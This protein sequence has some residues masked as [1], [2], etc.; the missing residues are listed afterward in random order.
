MFFDL[1]LLRYLY[2]YVT[3]VV[4]MKRELLCALLLVGLSTWLLLQ[5]D[6][7]AYLELCANKF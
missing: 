7:A 3:F 5:C 1:F 2:M 6:T 4:V